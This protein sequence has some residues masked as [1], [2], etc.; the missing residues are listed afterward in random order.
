MKRRTLAAVA[1]LLTLGLVGAAQADP[2]ALRDKIR[3]RVRTIRAAKLIEVLDLDE[4][5]AAKLFPVL[6]RYD[7]AIVTVMKDTGAA[8]RELKALIQSGNADNAKVNKLIDRMLANRD[9]RMKL[10]SDRIHDV[11]GVLAP[12]QVAKIV[13]ALPRIERGIQ[14]ELRRAAKRAAWHD[15]DDDE[16]DE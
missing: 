6:N 15:E 11:R 3:D 2:N 13:V 4:A 7:D 5:T 8:R 9:K 10:E 16:D 12:V 1:A 14:R